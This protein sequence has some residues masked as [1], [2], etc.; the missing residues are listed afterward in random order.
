VAEGAEPEAGKDSKLEFLV[1]PST[2]RP[3][4]EEKVKEDGQ[5]KQVDFRS[6]R[7]FENVERDQKIAV[8]HPG[9]EGKPGR[10]VKGERITPPSA[11]TKVTV[12]AG[13]GVVRREN[14]FFADMDGRVVHESGVL[15]VTDEFVVAKDVDFDV[16]HIDFVGSVTVYGDVLD[17]FN[18][19]GRKGVKIEKNVGACTIESEGDIELSGMTGRG[20]EGVIRC[21]GN[22]KARY[23]D[24]VRVE[25]QGNIE[26]RNEL[27]HSD[28]KCGGTLNVQGAIVGGHCLALGGVE[29]VS[30]GSDSSVK[31]HLRAGMDYRYLD[32]IAPVQ[33]KLEQCR[34]RSQD[35]ISRVGP[36]AR[37]PDP[38]ALPDGI[39]ARLKTML[40]E[41]QSLHEKR[42]ELEKVLKDMEEDVAEKA[43]P[44]INALKRLFGGTV[45][46]LGNTTQET[47]QTINR[48]VSVIQHLGVELRFLKYSPLHVKAQ[49][50]ERKLIA[51]E[52][53][54][55]REARLNKS[56]GEKS[57][58]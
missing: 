28:V 54:A 48:S 17:D 58:E 20:D 38:S 25:C 44:K 34:K 1:Q 26:V 49:E 2:R 35:L 46:Q 23:L 11:H 29:A 36:Y 27:M 7:R 56:P 13:K 24:N 52:E 43:N 3:V 32:R 53:K 5:V 4:L 47:R 31:T 57:S 8:L 16:G 18:V 51:A 22:L 39:K 55:E 6:A 30:V 41:I 33:A 14:E 21:G 40:E 19:R 50:I 42:E 12:K 9:H 45:I 15:S 10:N 37:N